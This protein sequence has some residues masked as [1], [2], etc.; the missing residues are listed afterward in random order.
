MFGIDNVCLYRIIN[1]T[2]IF[3]PSKINIF[4]WKKL[5][6]WIH[7]FFRI[8]LDHSFHNG[9]S[10][11]D[12]GN[13]NEIECSW[14]FLPWFRWDLPFIRRKFRLNSIWATNWRFT[15]VKAHKNQFSFRC[16]GI[17]SKWFQG[18]LFKQRFF[19]HSSFSAIET[20]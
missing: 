15:T 2:E 17:S 19:S 3:F 6:H 12:V 8:L 13:S 1:E 11:I 16:N 20:Q 10:M 7:S 18:I 9:L 5:S 14:E 4:D